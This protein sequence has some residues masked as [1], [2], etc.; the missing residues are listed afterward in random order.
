MVGFNLV[1]FWLLGK[2][3]N[4]HAAE[5]ADDTV[6][7]II[8]TK[9]KFVQ[10]VRRV[11]FTLM[12]SLDRPLGPTSTRPPLAAHFRSVILDSSVLDSERRRVRCFYR[13]VKVRTAMTLHMFGMYKTRPTG[14]FAG[15]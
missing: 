3:L 15:M 10:C 9:Q 7:N 6:L 14:G 1:I 5:C 13:R 12:A 2:Y 11:C 8:M 4:Y